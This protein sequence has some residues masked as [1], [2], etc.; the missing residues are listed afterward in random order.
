MQDDSITVRLGLE[1]V[2][3]VEHREHVDRFEVVVRYRKQGEACPRCGQWAQRVHSRSRQRKRD[4]CLWGKP[5]I[6]WLE[7][8]RFR[9]GWC[10]K[11]F[12][13][14]DPAF[15]PR[16]RTSRRLR[17]YLGEEARHQT[18]RRVAAQEGVGE[19]LVRRC[20]TERAAQEMASSEEPAEVTILGLDEYAVKR[21]HGYDTTICDLVNHRVVGVVSGRGSREVGAYL[22]R[23]PHPE[24]VQAVVMDMHEPYRHAV[25]QALGDTPIVADK[26]HV[27]RQ[28]NQALDEVRKRV[29]RQSWGAAR[30][31]L[32]RFKWL[33]LKGMERLT[34]KEQGRLT[35]LLEHEDLRRA[36]VLKEEFR[37]WYRT[38]TAEDAAAGLAR[39]AE[40]VRREGP[41]EFLPLLLTFRRWGQEVLNYFQWRYTNGYTEGLNNRIKA[42]KR[43][44]YGY[45]SR[46]TLRRLVL[47]GQGDR[48]RQAA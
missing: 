13:E 34:L 26:F 32:G 23:L 39:W 41:A 29:Q 6:L 48:A 18:I 35:R 9:C 20:L 42:I 27:V 17:E 46:D 2:A 14:G 19:G 4:R 43:R 44:G 10:R 38:A 12:S 33:L 45:R 24:R 1:G 30:R 47:Y 16:R 3:V 15:G 5:V 8:R 37:T 40:A 22:A 7:K 11:V 25:R 21:R 31:D 28:V 36:W